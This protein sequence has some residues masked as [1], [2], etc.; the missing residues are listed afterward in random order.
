VYEEDK[1]RLRFY[2]R[3]I[4]HIFD[5]NVEKIATQRLER[6]LDKFEEIPPV[7]QNFVKN[8]IVPDFQSR[9]KSLI[10]GHSKSMILKDSHN[11]PETQTY[12]EQ[13]AATKT[14]TRKPYQMN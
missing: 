10:F 8:R 7:L 6:L 1:M 2:F 11:T 12:H 13:L 14:T 4:K 3:E 5:T 9:R